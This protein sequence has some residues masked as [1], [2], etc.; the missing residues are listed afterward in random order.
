VSPPV[1]P[2]VSAAA[3][4]TTAPSLPGCTA[5]DAER[6]EAARRGDAAAFEKLYERHSPEV[7]AFAASRLRDRIEAEDVTQ[8]VFLVALHQLDAYAGRGRFESWLTGI[9]R[10]VIH[11]RIRSRSRRETYESIV[12]EA[13]AAHSTPEDAARLGNLAAAIRAELERLESWQARAVELVCLHGV[14]E[15]EVARRM[16]RSRH[17]VRTSVERVRN[18]VAGRCG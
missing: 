6:I 16:A 11:D 7:Y 8:E 13:S 4:E 2:D 5:R 15:R 10:N 12:S 17:A 1:P 14:P 9:A 3:P 18:R